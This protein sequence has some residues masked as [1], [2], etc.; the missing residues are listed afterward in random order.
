MARVHVVIPDDVLKDIEELA[1]KRGRSRFIAEA[2]AA[3]AYKEKM[4]RVLREGAGSIDAS[5]HPEWA[6]TEKV[7]EWV[8]NLRDTPTALE[9]SRGRIPA[10]RQRAD[11]LVKGK[12]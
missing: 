5:R 8:R 9:K 6:T 10:R 12:A 11:R 2:V 7:A 3:R 1:G 4:L